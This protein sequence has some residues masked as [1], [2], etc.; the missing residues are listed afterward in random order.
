MIIEN[1]NEIE[2]RSIALHPKNEAL[3]S[4][5]L[6]CGREVWIEEGDVETFAEGEKIALR[7][8]GKVL[9]TK[10]VNENGVKTVHAQLDPE[11][12]DFKKV[13][14]VTWVTADDAT[15]CEL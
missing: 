13:K 10:K 15:T 12:K 6:I 3:G 11:D 2:A 1:V 8:Y 5:A 7:N 4:K 14:V 9:I